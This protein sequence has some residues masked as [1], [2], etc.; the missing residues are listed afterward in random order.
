[1]LFGSIQRLIPLYERLL[2]RFTHLLRYS[3]LLQGVLKEVS[4]NILYLP[5]RA[6]P[7]L[8]EVP[9]HTHLV[10]AIYFQPLQPVAAV[11]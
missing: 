11:F 6:D 8:S 9:A 1:M 3:D 2:A 7:I 5:Q 10:Y 4:A